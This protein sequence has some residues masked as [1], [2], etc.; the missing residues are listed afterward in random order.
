MLKEHK[1]DEEIQEFLVGQS[2]AIRS[3]VDENLT[4]LY[5]YINGFLQGGHVCLCRFFY[6]G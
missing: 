4:G 1:S 6:T 3:A 2:T 5:G